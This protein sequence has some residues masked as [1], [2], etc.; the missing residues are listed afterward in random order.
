MSSVFDDHSNILLRRP[1]QSQT[2]LL[3]LGCIDNKNRKVTD[4]A[5][6][7]SSAWVPIYVGAVCEDWVAGVVRPE[8]VVDA[9][10][11]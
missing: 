5:A 6:F 1:L 7:L 2:D 3:C 4:C 10:R 11:I 8:S 9:D